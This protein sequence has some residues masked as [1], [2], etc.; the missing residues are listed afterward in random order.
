MN[1]NIVKVSALGAATLLFVAPFG[2]FAGEFGMAGARKVC[3]FPCRSRFIIDGKLA[4]LIYVAG[5]GKAFGGCLFLPAG[6][7]LVQSNR[8]C[9]RLTL[10]LPRRVWNGAWDSRR[11]QE[12]RLKITHVMFRP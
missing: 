8:W 6:N 1:N 5:W 9:L 7:E 2:E 4:I 10:S 11:K 3:S 12:L